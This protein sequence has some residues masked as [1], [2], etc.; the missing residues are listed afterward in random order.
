[1]LTDI[2]NISWCRVCVWEEMTCLCIICQLFSVRVYMFCIF[3]YQDDAFKHSNLTH[4]QNVHK[5]MNDL[6]K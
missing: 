1:M 3:V 6:I 2:L 5:M 4:F